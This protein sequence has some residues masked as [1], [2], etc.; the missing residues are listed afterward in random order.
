MSE[1]ITD[2]A[3]WVV[4]MVDDIT[5]LT[6]GTLQRDDIK[7]VAE[8]Y[9]REYGDGDEPITAGWLT[10]QGWEHFGDREWHLRSAYCMSLE[11]SQPSDGLFFVC[12]E[13]MHAFRLRT[14]RDVR[15]VTD[16]NKDYSA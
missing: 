9:L 14:R 3:L 16:R 4:R 1:S 11:I 8:A 5:N 13:G 10:S 15:W 2:K 12:S 6:D 7:A